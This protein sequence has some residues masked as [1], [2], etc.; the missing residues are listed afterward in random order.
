MRIRSGAA[1]AATLCAALTGCSQVSQP[2]PGAV[3]Y[4]GVP[5]AQTSHFRNV[6]YD[7]GCGDTTLIF[8]HVTWYPFS[9]S[10]PDELPADPLEKYRPTASAVGSG[11]TQP[12]QLEGDTQTSTETGAGTLLIYDGGLAYWESDSGDQHTWLTTDEIDYG[13]EC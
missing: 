7:L 11:T 5:G 13:W 2:V 8:N 6:E 12:G 4:H 10:N 3:S 1:I 9:P